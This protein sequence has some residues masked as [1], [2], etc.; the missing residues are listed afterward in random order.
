MLGLVAGAGAWADE[1]WPERI[2]SASDGAPGDEFGWAV[3]MDG[4]AAAV[5]APGDD[6]DQGA[7]YVFRRTGIEWV[8]EQ[9]LTAYNGTAGDRFGWSVAL[10]GD[11]LIVGAPYR[12]G[13]EGS[14]YV[15]AYSGTSWGLAGFF[16]VPDAYAGDKFGY[17]VAVSKH[18]VG[19]ERWN[20]FAV[21][22]PKAWAP[23]ADSGAV[24][25]FK[26]G[27]FY[28]KL[29]GNY[30]MQ[31]GFSVSLSGDMLAAGAPN[32]YY[33]TCQTGLLVTYRY[34]GGAWADDFAMVPSDGCSP[35]HDLGR[36]VAAKDD[37][38]VGGAPSW[39]N[40]GSA[41]VF[42]K[43]PIGYNWQE[44]QKFTGTTADEFGYAVALKEN[45]IVVG[46]P[47][48]DGPDWD[49]SGLGYVYGYD[50]ATWQEQHRLMVGCTQP[51]CYAGNSV[52]V[53]VGV[54]L[55]GSPGFGS[56][57]GI[58]SVYRLNCPDPEVWVDFAY[59][60]P[61]NGCFDTPYNTL[62]EGV[63]AIAAGE[64]LMIKSGTT[65]ETATISK[66]MTIQ[67]YGGPVTIGQ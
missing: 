15:Y 30:G 17:S 18:S 33:V 28:Q 9:K 42:R 26:A 5:G 60:G 36:S 58:V 2:I 34:N 1:L 38:V 51:G 4:N 29:S 25:I 7:V 54:A 62:A 47:L 64:T 37:L 8:E 16:V 52:A 22:A 19:E 65:P 21:G 23:D 12:N 31:L 61:E 49:D 46:A 11:L 35:W 20:W 57:L 50:G 3:S 40:P 53:D 6:S 67:A 27:S 14:A 24:Y 45:L 13:Y 41:Y 32:Y 63:S 56:S 59:V 55:M 10:R 66:A 39:P 44:E 43:D 48:A